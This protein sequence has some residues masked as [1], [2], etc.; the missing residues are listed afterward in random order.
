MKEGGRGEGRE[1]SKGEK[2]KLSHHG[3]LQTG[4]NMSFLKV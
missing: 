2:E 4:G 1:R 3:S